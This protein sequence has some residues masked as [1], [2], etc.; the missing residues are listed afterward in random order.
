MSAT[1]GPVGGL[2]GLNEAGAEVI[3]SSSWETGS[4]SGFGNTAVGLVSGTGVSTDVGGLVGLN[5]AGAQVIGSTSSETV[6]ATG[7]G[8]IAGGLVGANGGSITGGLAYGAVTGGT[9]TGGL[10]GY[11]VCTIS[12][13]STCDQVVCVT[14][15]SSAAAGGVILQRR[16]WPDHSFEFDCDGHRQRRQRRGGRTGRSQRRDYQWRLVGERSGHR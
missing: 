16:G 1:G 9:W 13:A 10:V 8:V 6:G 15:A 7:A 14:L 4:V 2:V 12:D 11:N 3:G 5:A